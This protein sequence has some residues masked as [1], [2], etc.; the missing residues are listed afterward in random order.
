[1][2]PAIHVPGTVLSTEYYS[3]GSCSP[4]ANGYTGALGYYSTTYWDYMR[5]V[6]QRSDRILDIF[7][8]SSSHQISIRRLQV[9]HGVM[10]VIPMQNSL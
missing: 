2:L 5:I 9:C 3:Y 1:M 7:R 8:F 10:D 6:N 4:G